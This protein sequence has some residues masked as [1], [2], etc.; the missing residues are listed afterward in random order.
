[1]KRIIKNVKGITLIALVV[2]IIVLLILAGVSINIAFNTGIISKSKNATTKYQEAT[3]NETNSLNEIESE[4]DKL[5]KGDSNKIPTADLGTSKKAKTVFTTK[6]DVTD[7]L[8]N[9]ARIP[10]GFK[11]ADDSAETI[12]GGV[13]IEDVS[14]GD[15][16][17][18]G[19]Q[20]VW[21]PV[22]KEIKSATETVDI[23]LGRYSFDSNGNATACTNTSYVEETAT[24]HKTSG[25]GNTIAK[26]IEKFKQS[27]SDNGG[28]YLARYEAGVTGYDSTVSTGNSSGAASWTGYANGKLTIKSNQQ[29]W[30]YIT[31]NKAADIAR[32]MYSA[33]VTSDLVNSYAWD[34]AIVYIEKCGTNAN[35][36]N[37]IGKATDNNLANTGMTKLKSTSA[38]DAQCNIYDMAGSVYEW[39][40]ESGSNT[41]YRCV[42]RGGVYY[43]SNYFSA[44]R[45]GGDTSFAYVS[46]GF[47]PLLYL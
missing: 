3:A 37:Q 26:D 21:I 4:V 31:Q 46:I 35:Y 38:I 1:M 25:D 32:N 24:E 22:G 28:Y 11:I 40:T 20:F 13:V 9:K 42:I 43:D 41:L 12:P 8:G 7:A 16:T 30:N 6:T 39:T 44:S 45:S 23:A 18:V 47:R 14:A 15:S 36:A 10:V 29:V 33:N 17:S 34:T 5:S 2:T 19:N 27:V